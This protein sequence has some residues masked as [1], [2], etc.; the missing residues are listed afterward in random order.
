MIQE[1][2]Y[3]LKQNLHISA[4]I[5]YNKNF[6]KHTYDGD[7]QV[8]FDDIYD[9][10]SLTKILAT[11]PLLMELEEQGVI[12]LDTQ[13]SQILPSYKN[14]N[15]AKI[16]LKAMLSHYAKLKPWEPFYEHTLD[17]TTKRPSEKYYRTERSEKFNIEVAQ[18][19]YLRSDYQDSIQEIIKNSKLLTKTQYKYSDFPYYILKKYIEKYY[20]KPLDVL[21]EDHFYKPWLLV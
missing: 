15:K 14:S 18:N 4:F 17:S 12:N 6:G 7:T 2:A 19:L 9:V 3:L 20:D 11:L 1:N 8:G 10:A 16:T 21:V 13:L 5:I